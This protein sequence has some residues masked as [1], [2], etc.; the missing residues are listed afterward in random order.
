MSASKSVTNKVSKGVI[1]VLLLAIPAV[2]GLRQTV[3]R[4]QG[5]VPTV[6]SGVT[7]ANIKMGMTFTAQQCRD[8]NLQA[9]LSHTKPLEKIPHQLPD[10]VNVAFGSWLYQYGETNFNSSTAR[11]YL[12]QN[13]LKDACDEILKWRFTRVKGV[14]VDCSIKSSGCGGVWTRAQNNNQLCLGK[15]TINQYLQ[16]IGAEP[17]KYEGQYTN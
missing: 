6:C 11:K 13:R 2:E 1:A 7:G 12:T 15:L 10:R 5:G 16:R 14:K 17:L 9:I 3:Y 4:D 8:M